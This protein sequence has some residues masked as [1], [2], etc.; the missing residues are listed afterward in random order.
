MSGASVKGHGVSGV[1]NQTVAA[2][3]LIPVTSI[4]PFD[5]TQITNKDN[6]S[7][8]QAGD[9]CHPLPSHGHAPAIATS[10]GHRA[11]CLNAG[12]M[13]RQDYETETMVVAFSGR[14]RGDDGRGYDR[15][16]NVTGEIAG[17]VDTVKPGNIAGPSVGVRRL[18][19]KECERLQGFPD[20]WTLVP[21]GPKGKL[22]ADGP[23]YKAIGNSM[24]VPV[25]RWI[26]KRI[27]EQHQ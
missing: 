25:M 2:G 10:T 7:N 1:N 11:H 12:G 14:N 3:H 24:A 6:R 21:H 26:G 13:G 16:P 18:T 9:P 20:D 5:T 17:T 19:P 22:A 4:I 8:P 27:Q 23:R 15:P